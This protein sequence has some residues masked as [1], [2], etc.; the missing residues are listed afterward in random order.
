MAQDL[1]DGVGHGLAVIAMQAG[2]AAARPRPGSGEGAGEPR[3]DPG[4]QSGVARG[5][6]L[7]AGGHV[8]CRTPP[9]CVGLADLA[10]LLDRV[11]AAGPCASKCQGIPAKCRE[12]WLGEV[13]YVVIQ[14]AL[15]YVLRHRGRRLPP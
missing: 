4:H 3:G 1:H 5:A 15:T 13:S 14:E 7:G 11:R 6:A 9:A 12:I 2:V 10:A 8:G